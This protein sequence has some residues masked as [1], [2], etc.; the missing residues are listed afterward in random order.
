M[1]INQTVGETKIWVN[2]VLYIVPD[3][4]AA[5]IERLKAECIDELT[6]QKKS[7]DAYYNA[8]IKRLRAGELA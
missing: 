5:E 1:N 8:I 7:L 6:G 2:N 3:P 4:V